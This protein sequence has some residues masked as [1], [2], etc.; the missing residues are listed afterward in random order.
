LRF[1]IFGG[2]PRHF[3]GFTQSDK[4]SEKFA[5]VEEMMSEYF[6]EEMK[7]M[8][9]AAWNGILQYLM[10]KLSTAANLAGNDFGKNTVKSLMWHTS[11][12][13]DFFWGSKF[14]EFLASRI[15]EGR[16]LTIQQLL[17]QVTG[18]SGVGSLFEYRGHLLLLKSD[19]T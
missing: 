18:R 12:C 10:R 3:V 4:T 16:E 8:E 17:T 13:R 6:S 11:D 2:N 5:F 7:T 19:R 9:A 1:G 14:M 15:M